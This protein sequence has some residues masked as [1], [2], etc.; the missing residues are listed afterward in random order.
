MAL[1]PV[2][3]RQ[4]LRRRGLNK[5]SGLRTF[6]VEESQAI[7]QAATLYGQAFPGVATGTPICFDYDIR[8]WPYNLP[9]S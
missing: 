6:A 9:D 8:W 2:K 4:S 7:S 3:E 1:I 5:W